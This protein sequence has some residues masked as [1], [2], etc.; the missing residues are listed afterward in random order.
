MRVYSLVIVVFYIWIMNEYSGV[1][2]VFN[3]QGAGWCTEEP[4]P[5]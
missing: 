4:Y 1:F 2:G 3:C 5:R